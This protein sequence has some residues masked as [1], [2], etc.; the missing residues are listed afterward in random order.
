[1]L[2]ENSL[3]QNLEKLRQTLRSGQLALA[4]WSGGEWAISAVPGAGKS[5][6]L[7][8]AAAI[9]IARHQ[10]QGQRQLMIVTYTRS[11]AAGIKSKIKERLRELNLP[12]IGFSVQ[13]LHSLA[14][15]I[16]SRHPELSG[17]NLGNA[18]L[19]IPNIN[20]RLVR[21]TVENWIKVN[22]AIFQN[23]LEAG[24]FDGEETEKLRRQ[25]VL[26]TEILPSL[27]LTVVGEA[28]SSGLL[29]ESVWELSY[30]AQTDQILT[31]GAGLYEQYQKLML[32]RNWIDY[33][34]M[35]LAALKV[36]GDRTVGRSWQQQ[37][38]GVFEDEAQDSS[39]LQEQLITRLAQDPDDSNI[40]NLIRVGDPNQAINSTFTPADPMYF[41]WFCENCQKQQKFTNMDQAGRSSQIIIDAANFVL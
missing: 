16:A 34:D 1:M 2:S 7:S 37:I 27:A 18:T 32:G 36:L 41:N 8:V 26:R 22:P 6:S 20:H 21:E 5:Y 19:I 11:A 33:D 10:L 12:G 14:L 3:T 31:I 9:A 17:L 23:L 35:I 25:S 39:P 29:P 30:L 24:D 4:D 28:K 38:F 40:V 15:Q 13:T